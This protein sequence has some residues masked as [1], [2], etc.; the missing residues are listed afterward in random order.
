MID[1]TIGVY[2][3]E[4]NYYSASWT[5]TCQTNWIDDIYVYTDTNGKVAFQIGTLADALLCEIAATNFVQGFGNVNADY[6]KGWSI[7]AVTTLPT[8]SN[9]TFVPYKAILPDVYED[10]TFHDKVGIGTT[11]PR[12][13][14]QINGNGNSW[15]EAP[16][17]RLWDTT[18]SKGWLVGNVN[19]Y[20]AG[21]FYIRTM[22]S[23]S[24]DPSSTQQEFTIKHATGYVGIGTTSP[25]H[26]LEVNGG[27]RAGIAGNASANTPALKVYAA[28]ASSST[29]AA[30][31]IQQGTDEGDTILFADYEPHVEW[32]I[33]C[34]NSTDQIHFTAGSST[35]NLGSKTFYSNAGGARTAYIKFNHDLTDGKTLIGGQIGM[36]RD[37]NGGIYAINTSSTPGIDSN[38]GL[39]VQRTANVNDYNTRLKYYPT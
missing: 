13:K 16:S 30:I 26:K 12:G 38:W 39:E 4:N 9:L 15:N 24:G 17:I 22:P 25:G 23:I 27:I 28:G 35:N 5:G 11:S 14:L 10:V 36:G 29:T 32:G 37:Y 19:N 7:V 2:A 31:A 1:M 21:D 20:T 34:Q 8:Q 33:S 18:N 3:G 6:S